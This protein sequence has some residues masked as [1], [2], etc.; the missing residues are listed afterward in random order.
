[1]KKW[2]A[3]WFI[4]SFTVTHSPGRDDKNV[5]AG[6]IDVLSYTINL[7]V[8]DT[9]DVVASTTEIS[10]RVLKNLDTLKF[11]LKEMSVTTCMLDDLAN[12]FEQKEG[13]F[14]VVSKKNLDANS[15]HK[16]KVSYNGTPKDGLF[17]GKNK[18]R[19]FCAFADNWPNRASYWFPCIDHPSDK[20][21]VTFHITVPQKYEV[22]ANG[23]E[24][25]TSYSAK[26]TTYSFSMSVPITTY[27][28]VF[29]VCDFAISKTQTVSGVPI[30]YYTFPED[31]LNAI[32]SFQRVPDMIDYFEKI[33]GKYP[34]SK[35]ALVE[36]STKYG[37]M[38]NSSAI[39]LPQRSPSF[40]GRRN[41]DETLAHEI[42]HQWFGDDVS[43]SN[44]SELWLSEGFA[45]YFSAL[46]FESRDGENRFN[47][48]MDRI[49]KTYER[50]HIKGEAVVTND[51]SKIE[52]LLN[53]ENYD[54]GAL[55]LNELRKIVGDKIFFKGVKEY[56]TK[57]KHSNVSTEDFENVMS[58]TS[59]RNLKPLF[60]R[61]LYEA[62][63][64]SLEK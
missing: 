61:W 10:F 4:I 20:A 48:I 7:A 59:N 62:E 60:H 28:M 26:S 31:S 44:W 21:E 53:A 38:E 19:K 37:G 45:T 58:S 1:M 49:E 24:T 42:A 9:S 22:V 46:Y 18:Y 30:Y 50:G 8:S 52:E 63:P 56:Y 39:F 55:F 51:Y 16:M 40:S 41:N 23:D 12:S 15:V 35:L 11:N 14:L 6:K 5:M 57:Y 54:K 36:S 17:I 64:D 25:N 33:I 34:Y 43:I 3:V 27:C 47:S 13:I 29:G 2:L 32:N